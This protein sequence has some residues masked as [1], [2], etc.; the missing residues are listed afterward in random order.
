MVKNLSLSSGADGDD[1]S[2]A[3]RPDEGQPDRPGRPVRR[4]GQQQND[5]GLP[6][7]R[8]ERDE[9]QHELRGE[10]HPRDQ[11]AAER[12][13]PRLDDTL[14]RAGRAAEVARHHG[15]AQRSS[16]TLR[17]PAGRRRATLQMRTHHVSRYNMYASSLVAFA[18]F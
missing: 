1:R 6:P 15:R 13:Q 4:A 18:G 7:G 14:Y 11:E 17:D 10:S 5:A 12:H 16:H 8:P 2:P 3:E 9:G